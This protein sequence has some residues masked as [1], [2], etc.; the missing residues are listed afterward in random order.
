VTENRALTSREQMLA[1]Q[2]I[3]TI[4]EE[5][6]GRRLESRDRDSFLS[7]TQQIDR[8]ATHPVDL[9]I[10][11]GSAVAGIAR[12]RIPKQDPGRMRLADWISRIEEV[13]PAKGI[14]L[15]PIMSYEDVF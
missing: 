11:S 3:L 6:V 13:E 2:V 1:R 15:P 7:R 14:R 12:S 9:L 4:W 10:S 8:L 5:V